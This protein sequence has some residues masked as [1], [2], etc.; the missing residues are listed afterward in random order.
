[1]LRAEE[2][3]DR[4]VFVDVTLLPTVLPVEL[5]VPTA[6][7]AADDELCWPMFCADVPVDVVGGGSVAIDPMSSAGFDRV[8]MLVVVSSEAVDEP[9]LSLDSEVCCT[10]TAWTASVPF[11]VLVSLTFAAFD[12]CGSVDTGLLPD[13]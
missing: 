6:E 3:D 13:S 11:A 7:T 12:F 10:G 9:A 5:P 2:E 1:M 4:V 8:A